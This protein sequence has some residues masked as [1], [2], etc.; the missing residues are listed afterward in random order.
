MSAID[1][2]PWRRALRSYPRSWRERHGEAMIGTLLD[3]AEALGLE[4]PSRRDRLSLLASGLAVR[5]GGW[6]PPAARETLAAA[7]AATGL[8]LALVFAMFSGFSTS[9]DDALPFEPVPS[10]ALPAVALWAMS[11]ILLLF[12]AARVARVTLALTALA[13]VG[14]LVFAQIVP[15][16]GPRMITGA[17]LVLCALV[18]L[19]APVRARGAVAVIAAVTT[20]ILVFFHLFF[21][22]TVGSVDVAIWLR[23]LTE[24]FTGFLA[25]VV[26]VLALLCAAVG[27]RT[28]ARWVAGVAVMWTAIW[29]ARLLMWDVWAGMLGLAVVAG[30]AGVGVGVFRAGAAWARGRE[31]RP[32]AS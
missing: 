2:T 19:L 30:V 29:L 23:V 10:P 31:P 13:G 21:E 4:A 24:E 25:G 11:G 12:G 32:G 3:E 15:S 6:M 20:G 7:S 14:A 5:L 18:A 28:L 9:M 8:S 27:A 17:T 26:W 16:V 22:V 1:D